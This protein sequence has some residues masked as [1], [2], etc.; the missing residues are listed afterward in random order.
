MNICVGV[1]LISSRW[2]QY[3]K[4]FT[5]QIKVAKSAVFPVL[6]QL[7]PLACFFVLFFIGNFASSGNPVKS[8][9]TN[10]TSRRKQHE[11][12]VLKISA[13]RAKTVAEC[14]IFAV[15]MWEIFLIYIFGRFRSRVDVST[16]V[17]KCIICPVL[18]LLLQIKP[19][20]IP[21]VRIG[22]IVF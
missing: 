13:V 11:T 15:C 18:A 2:Q 1:L 6:G 3:A 4:E 19:Y 5:L 14:R 7:E 12:R 16:N 22:F 20:K 10:E 8:K 21:C 17:M 9:G